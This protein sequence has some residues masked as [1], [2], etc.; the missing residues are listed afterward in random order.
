MTSDNAG[1]PTD[2]SSAADAHDTA[3]DTQ[4]DVEPHAAESAEQEGHTAPVEQA[5]D[6][7]RRVGEK[8]GAAIPRTSKGRWGAFTAAFAAAAGIAVGWVIRRGR[9]RKLPWRR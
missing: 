9:R 8:M 5:K 7:A 4:P 2:S 6:T 1:T 3:L